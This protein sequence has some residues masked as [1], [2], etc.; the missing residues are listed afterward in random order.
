MV[1]R[2]FFRLMTSITNVI[3]FYHPIVRRDSRSYQ[4]FGNADR[5]RKINYVLLTSM[6]LR[7]QIIS[8]IRQFVEESYYFQLHGTAWLSHKM[9]NI[10]KCSFQPEGEEPS[11][12]VT[13]QIFVAQDTRVSPPCSREI[14]V[15]IGSLNKNL[16]ILDLLEKKTIIDTQIEN[17][18]KFYTSALKQLVGEFRGIRDAILYEVYIKKGITFIFMNYF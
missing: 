4:D 10:K 5:F 13:S 16:F 6:F 9:L 15:R 17:D 3:F 7:P 18:N 1:S 14:L 2:F 12:E 11:N 8:T